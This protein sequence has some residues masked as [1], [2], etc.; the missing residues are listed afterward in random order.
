MRNFSVF[1]G[2]LSETIPVVHASIAGCRIIGR[3]AV[4]NRKGLVVPHSTTD[5]E[6]Q[7]LRN[8]LPDAVKIQRVEERLSALGNV[9]A[10]NDYVSLVHPDIDRETEGEFLT[11]DISLIIIFDFFLS[12]R[13]FRMFSALRS[14]DK[15]FLA[16][17]WSALTRF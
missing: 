7:H 4:G 9:I 12:Q 10:C 2:E 17:T 15:P 3:L 1:E 14:L 6:L 5:L 13:L 16:T 8:S 11:F